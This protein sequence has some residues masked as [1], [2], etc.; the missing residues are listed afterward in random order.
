MR[1]I[2]ENGIY[3]PKAM[4]MKKL[5]DEKIFPEVSRL[6]LGLF[7]VSLVS[8]VIV[9]FQY[10]PCGNVFK[11][12]EEITFSYPYGFFIRGIHYRAAE[13]FLVFTLIHTAYHFVNR[14]YK[15][16]MGKRWVYLT[17]SSILVFF[18]FSPV[19]S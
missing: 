16:S 19:L 14:S 13:L 10:S 9:A 3:F 15:K 2:K 11:N 6:S 4:D 17:F 8:G 5:L 7:W 1:S 12:V 18:C